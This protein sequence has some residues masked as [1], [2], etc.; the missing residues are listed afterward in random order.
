MNINQYMD[1]LV[2]HLWTDHF[3]LNLRRQKM[4][5]NFEQIINFFPYPINNKQIFYRIPYH[6]INK[7]DDRVQDS[8]KDINHVVD[9]ICE[10][11][12]KFVKE[13]QYTTIFKLKNGIQIKIEPKKTDLWIKISY[14]HASDAKI[15]ENMLNHVD[16][17]IM[18]LKR[19]AYKYIRKDEH[20]YAFLL[21]EG[22]WDDNLVGYIGLDAGSISINTAVVDEL[23][24]VL[25]TD[26]SFTEGD[27]IGNVKKS[28]A[29]VYE[30]LP[31]NIRILGTGV[32]GSG[33][34]ISGALIN[35]DVYE[36]EL[37]AHAKAALHLVPEAKV[38][39]D[40][41]GQDSKVMY[42]KDG[43]L[44]DAGMNKKC[45][46]G[47]GSFLNA[48]ASR[49]G[50]PIE[51]FG[52]ISQQA[53]KPYRFSSMCTVFVGR[54]L[55]AEQA[56]G[57]T[58]ENIIAGLHRSLATNF[59]STLGINKKKIQTPI[60]FQ[61]GVASNI[62]VKKALEECLEESRGEKI[63]LIIPMFSNVM[64][65]VGMAL[66][67]L[68]ETGGCTKFRG[69]ED[70]SRIRSEFSECVSRNETN[71]SSNTLCDLVKLY[72]GDRLIN[73]LY[74]CDGYYQRHKS[75]HIRNENQDTFSINQREKVRMGA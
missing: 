3:H 56:K 55:I 19:I 27:V 44:D 64:G 67:A 35:A 40:I 37:D 62:G 4:D 51:Q 13:S 53:K 29:G 69:F 12:G 15:A 73:T 6:F 5:F 7:N 1:G 74:A 46:A 36:T 58:K 14:E 18:S 8:I 54:D 45:G 11:D 23:G 30:K 66:F 32:T 52:E 75:A 34:E 61:G 41:G 43:M 39:F 63:E 47:T 17:G 57:N 72:I 65:A 50:I 33:H 38:I 20:Q 24:T 21:K 71:C 48:Q 68:K 28:I 60:V 31:R 9:I 26:Y 70:I 10:H 16:M 2:S 42:I 25:E 59:F 22:K 49:L